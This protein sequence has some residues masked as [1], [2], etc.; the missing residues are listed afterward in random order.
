MQETIQKESKFVLGVTV[1]H[2][3]IKRIDAIRGSIP[4]S[5]VVEEV[6][7]HFVTAIEKEKRQEKWR[8]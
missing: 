6:L 5:R 3:L 4:R 1:D 8:P 2:E 7:T